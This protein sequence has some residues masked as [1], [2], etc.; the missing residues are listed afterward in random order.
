MSSSL[1]LK[2]IDMILKE[3]SVL[4]QLPKKIDKRELLLLDSL[5]FTIEM[6]EYSYEQLYGRLLNISKTEKKTSKLPIVY[7][8]AWNIIDY[9]KRF[10]SLYKKMPSINGYKNI[11]SLQYI[12]LF[13]NT[14]QHIEDR[15]DESI[16]LNEKPIYGSLKWE[17]KNMEKGTV[18]TCLSISGI[19]YHTKGHPFYFSDLKSSNE[20]IN[21]IILET[22]SKRKMMEINISNIIIDLK[23]IILNLEISVE[24]IM[25]SNNICRV[26]WTKRQ[27]IVLFMKNK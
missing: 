16:L 4:R 20:E 5:R 6:I 2:I 25:V 1:T 22:V 23:I 14:L 19:N 3:N 24:K 26:D 7:L 18:M 12:R 13:R 17:F 10:E 21:N 11:E 9:T 27:D 8:Y 15:V